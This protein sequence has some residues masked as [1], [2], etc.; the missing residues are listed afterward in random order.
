MRRDDTKKLI[1]A[2]IRRRHNDALRIKRL[3][4]RLNDAPFFVE[5][6][7]LIKEAC[8]N[9]ERLSKRSPTEDR[10]SIEHLVGKLRGETQRL[11]GEENRYG[12]NPLSAKLHN[13]IVA[14]YSF[15][16]KGALK[17]IRSKF[18]LAKNIPSVTE[19]KEGREALNLIKR[20]H[21]LLLNAPKQM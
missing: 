20:A 10:H 5:S 2:L 12:K 9:L 19:N 21:N 8:R 14:N 1:A 3:R 15:D 11:I 13:N 16:P 7:A 18:S 17:D 4:S 6:K